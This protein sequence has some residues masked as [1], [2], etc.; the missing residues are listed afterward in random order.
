V[1][2]ASTAPF[3]GGGDPGNSIRG[4]KP[5]TGDRIKNRGTAKAQ[6]VGIIPGTH[7]EFTVSTIGGGGKKEE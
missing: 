6:K 7:V 4:T 2:K 3:V 5:K 1:K